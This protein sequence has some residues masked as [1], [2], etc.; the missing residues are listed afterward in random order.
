MSGLETMFFYRNNSTGYLIM[1]E[2]FSYSD[3]RTPIKLPD[4]QGGTARP[5]TQVLRNWRGSR[6]FSSQTLSGR[7]ILN[8]PWATFRIKHLTTGKH[9]APLAR[10]WQRINSMFQLSKANTYMMSRLKHWTPVSTDMYSST[11]KKDNT[12]PLWHHC[13]YNMRK[14]YFSPTLNL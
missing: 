4:P 8:L 1:Y 10:N 2:T 3:E 7:L 12:I 11:G 14:C 6:L 5:F 13:Y 9:T